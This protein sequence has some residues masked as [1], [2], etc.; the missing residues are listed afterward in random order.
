MANRALDHALPL[1]LLTK[2]IYSKER[3]K[4]NS[5][6]ESLSE[7]SSHDSFYDTL[8]DFH[9]DPVDGN[10]PEL[11][12]FLSQEEMNKSL[13]IARE[14]FSG[15]LSEDQSQG[16][17]LKS[18]NNPPDR[19][20]KELKLSNTTSEN[21]RKRENVMTKVGRAGSCVKPGNSNARG[22]ISP[23]LTASPSI[24]RTLQAQ[25]AF[26][27]QGKSGSSTLPTPKGRNKPINKD[28]NS[29]SDI[30]QKA[31]TFIEELSA[32]FRETNK[33]RDRRPNGDSSS[34]DS[35]YLSPKKENTIV[36]SPTI[37]GSEIEPQQELNTMEIMSVKEETPAKTETESKP[38]VK[39]ERAH[40]E[41][42]KSHTP[43]SAARF[44]QK[45]KSQEVAEGSRVGLECRVTGDPFPDV[46]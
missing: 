30:A 36:M 13:D 41:T 14:A 44:I 1:S 18:H 42:N 23:F 45:L 43:P 27:L 24:I 9:G 6:S 26:R 20:Y 3:K 35:G 39:E 37:I 29:Q 38:P 5:L 22:M 12:A 34:P 2:D 15:P 21:S 32:I 40:T 46:R 16:H 4:T 17:I 11:S 7:A 33:A 25:K 28:L 19:S 31:A 10:F 8:S